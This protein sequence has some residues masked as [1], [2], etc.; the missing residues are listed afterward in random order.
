MTTE[1]GTGYTNSQSY[2]KPGDMGAGM[3]DGTSSESSAASPLYN[4]VR[5]EWLPWQNTNAQSQ[6]TCLTGFG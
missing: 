6:L 5:P 3:Y 1:Y 4:N 2:L